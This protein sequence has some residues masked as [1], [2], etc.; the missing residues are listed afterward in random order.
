MPNL[1]CDETEKGTQMTH[2][3][4]S[5]FQFWVG[6]AATKYLNGDRNKINWK[7]HLIILPL[8]ESLNKKIRST[9][10]KEWKK[11]NKMWLDMGQTFEG[12]LFKCCA[13][14]FGF[15]NVISNLMD[16]KHCWLQWIPYWMDWKVHVWKDIVRVSWGEINKL[17]I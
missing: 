10:P 15:A 12:N 11:R 9:S 1:I 16:M 14:R 4:K 6:V 3:I 13:T 17:K 7:I 5:K 2:K 8:T